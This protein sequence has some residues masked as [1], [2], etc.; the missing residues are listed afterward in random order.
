M[1]YPRSYQVQSG[2]R[3]NRR[4]RKHLIP[5]SDFHAEPEP[6]D[7]FDATGY[8]QSPADYDPGCPSLTPASLKSSKTLSKRA[9]LCTKASP[10]HYVTRSG[11]IVQ[12]S[13]KRDL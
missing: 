5:S 10:D 9:N 12:P 8:Q 2:K 3:I 6:E 4:N 1:P 7:N 11:R 13:K